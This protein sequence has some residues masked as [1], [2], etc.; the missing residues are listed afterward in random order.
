MRPAQAPGARALLVVLDLAHEIRPPFNPQAAIAEVA[1]LLKSYG[2]EARTGDKYAAGFV[3]EGFAQWPLT[4]GRSSARRA[5][6]PLFS[7]RRWPCCGRRA[8]G[9]SILST[10][11]WFG[12]AITTLTVLLDR[13]FDDSRTANRR[14][15]SLGR[16]LRRH[17]GRDSQRRL[18]VVDFH[19]LRGLAP[20]AVED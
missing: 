8:S 18:L 14:Q 19:L 11:R 5:P 6:R 20:A 10:G 4:R 16:L 7:A 9:R 1:V 3:V 13:A 12:F 17:V 2:V 15:K